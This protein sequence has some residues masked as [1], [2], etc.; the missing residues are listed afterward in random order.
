[1]WQG[2]VEVARTLIGDRIVDPVVREWAAQA[3]VRYIVNGVL[4]WLDSGSEER[5]DDFVVLSTHG[6]LAMFMAWIDPTSFEAL[7]EQF[8]S[9]HD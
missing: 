5:D 2:A 3:A 1:H 4:M 6:L 8:R 9:T 7:S